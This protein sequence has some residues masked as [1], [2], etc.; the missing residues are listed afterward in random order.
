VL[1][2]DIKGYDTRYP[3]FESH[4]T[5]N[6]IKNSACDMNQN[7]KPISCDP[8][9]RGTCDDDIRMG[10]GVLQAENRFIR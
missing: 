7:I 6:N 3:Y 1:F 2:N 5:N 9:K 10:L 8:K 4:G